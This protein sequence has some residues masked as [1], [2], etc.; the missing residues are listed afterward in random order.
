M[1]VEGESARATHHDEPGALE[2]AENSGRFGPVRARVHATAVRIRQT[3]HEDPYTIAWTLCAVTLAA[4]LLYYQLVSARAVFDSDWATKSILASEILRTHTLFPRDFWFVNSPW[5]VG[6]H[7]PLLFLIPALGNTLTANLL[8][9]VF[10]T[11]VFVPMFVSYLHRIGLS[12]SSVAFGSLLALGSVSSNW[13]DMFYGQTAYGY[14]CLVLLFLLHGIHGFVFTAEHTIRG[15]MLAVGSAFLVGLTGSRGTVMAFL[16]AAGAFSA[17]VAT[18][19]VKTLKWTSLCWLSVAFAA[20]QFA[21]ALLIRDL[22][23]R[24]FP[25]SFTGQFGLVSALDQLFDT[26]LPAGFSFSGTLMVVAPARLGAMIALAVTLICACRMFG[27]LAEEWRFLLLFT[28]FSLAGTGYLVAFVEPVAGIG[29]YLIPSVFMM[30]V[31]AAIGS[32]ARSGSWH[33]RLASLILA[34]CITVASLQSYFRPI[35]GSEWK[36]NQFR[37]AESV[38]LSKHLAESN[39]RVA[40]G[41]YWHASMVTVVSGGQVSVRAVDFRDGLP[42]P[43]LHLAPVWWYS[44]PAAGRV[45]LVLHDKEAEQVNRHELFRIL[46]KP[47]LQTR[48]GPYTIDVFNSDQFRRLP[49]WR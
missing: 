41:S 27:T 34:G 12:R 42:F 28:L 49:H 11:F 14:V 43:Y 4:A 5:F 16:P 9:S 20:G 47:A 17:M 36:R 33:G 10:F 45:A 24:Q 48:S 29:R 21:R 13:A 2:S 37:M 1:R 35:D 6:G 39:V 7:L 19:S 30:F 25:L 26:T 46:G 22:L 23:V 40:Y 32:E 38:A 44:Q 8:A 18:G 31:V 3:L 15:A